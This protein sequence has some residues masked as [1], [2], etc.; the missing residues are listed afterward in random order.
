M[1]RHSAGATCAFGGRQA[2]FLADFLRT[3]R[4]IDYAG[5]AYLFTTRDGTYTDPLENSFGLYNAD[6]SPKD[7]VAAVEEVIDENDAFDEQD[8]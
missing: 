2:Q 8:L 6:W 1:P 7:A 5:P 3:W 4:D